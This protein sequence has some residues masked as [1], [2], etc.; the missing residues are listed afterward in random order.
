MLYKLIAIIILVLSAIIT[1]SIIQCNSEAKTS[2]NV[3]LSVKESPWGYGPIG[4]IKNNK[5]YIIKN[6]K[7]GDIIYNK[8]SAVLKV[9]SANSEEV[10]L[11]SNGA[12]EISDN[13]GINFLEK[14][15]NKF[16]L[17]KGNVIK[18]RTKTMDSG[19]NIE[20]KY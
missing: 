18:L 12:L 15:V 14:S 3:F 4:K 13:T 9:Q 19:S 11:L 7:Q 1:T 5:S 8:Y 10:V 6:I 16:I 2:D 17:K 20:V